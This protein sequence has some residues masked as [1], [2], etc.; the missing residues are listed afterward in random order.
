ML[1]RLDQVPETEKSVQKRHTERGFLTVL[2]RNRNGFRQRAGSKSFFSSLLGAL[3][4]DGISVRFGF[5]PDVL[6]R[7]R[8]EM[9]RAADHPF[10]GAEPAKVHAFFLQEPC[11]AV[12][13]AAVRALAA[14]TEAWA[15]VGDI[16]YLSAPG[17]IGRS[18][19][20]NGLHR[21]VPGIVTARNLQTVG[22]VAAVMRVR[23]TDTTA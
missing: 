13:T 14:E 10:S 8:E 16:F 15:L 21:V 6:L 11:G 1:K 17:G 23:G 5:C 18:T 20:A 19:L 9:N 2:G 7:N 4:A 22:A 3:L 12:D